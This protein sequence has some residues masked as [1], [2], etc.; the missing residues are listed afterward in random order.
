MM[1]VLLPSDAFPPGQVGGSAWS[2]Y[3]LARALIG[4]GRKV[5]AVVPERSATPGLHR[6]EEVTE[7]PTWRYHYHAPELPIV[8]NI[9]RHE[10][11][12]PALAEVLVHLGGEMQQ[13]QNRLVIHAQ[14]VQTIPAAVLAGQR[15]GV[16]VIATVRDHWPWHYFATGLHGERVPYP[17]EERTTAAARWWGTATDTLARMSPL[18]G[19]LALAALP[20]MLAHVRRRAALLARA[21][22]VVA[23]SS[24]IARRLR[25]VVPPQQ[26]HTI[27]NMV[28]CAELARLAAE[29][30][31]T[32]QHGPF[33]LY[34]G[35][36]EP[37]KGAAL[38]VEIMREVARLRSEDTTDGVP[39][40]AL[41]VVGSGS[42]QGHIAREMARLGVNVYICSWASHNEVIRLMA[43][44]EV[45]LFPSVW[46]EP[47]SRVLLE[48]SSVGAPILAMPTGGTPD[49]LTNGI[50]GALE[51]TPT[52]FA[53]RL[54]AL[55]GNRAQRQQLGQE[56]RR[57]A[58][59][60]FSVEAVV[61]R[62]EHLYESLYTHHL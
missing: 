23:V 2:A 36:L 1:N 37:N 49:L 4:R 32:P 47:F 27:P 41:L 42:L 43:R 10:K 25:G 30:P 53:R 17:Y 13:Q 52:S 56:A 33:L 57:L 29:P 38:L 58:C 46:G 14:H 48:A 15:L 19:V 55:M 24:Y 62:V 59:Q 35:K 39:L 31:E 44:C 54:I 34:V 12:W 22:A 45:L 50:N 9:Y 21:D 20:Y 40:P 18:K 8:K 3:T 11:L 16:P 60:C 28:D 7:V 51:T 6:C 61:P 26:I 5:V